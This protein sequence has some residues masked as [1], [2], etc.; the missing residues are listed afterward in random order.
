MICKHI[1]LITFFNEP[2]LMF[3]HTVEWFQ[4]LLCI[5]KNSFKPQSFVCTQF[6]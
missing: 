3:L 4:V 1:L 5:T 6:K 2:E